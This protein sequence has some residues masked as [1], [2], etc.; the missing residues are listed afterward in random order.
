MARVSGWRSGNRWRWTAAFS[1]ALVASAVFGALYANGAGTLGAPALYKSFDARLVSGQIRIRPP[2]QAAYSV[3]NGVA[4]L[5]FGTVIDAA[6]GTVELTSAT[7]KA[8]GTQTGRFYDGAFRV[9]QAKASSALRPAHKTVVA[10]TL[11]LVGSLVCT[12]SGASAAAKP[13]RVRRRLWGRDSGGNW[14]TRGHNASATTVHTRWLVEDFCGG[15]ATSVKVVRG[16]VAV[17]CGNMRKQSTTHA[18]FITTCR[19]R[20][21]GRYA[22]GTVRG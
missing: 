22:A 1:S 7:G 2:G 4:V 12:A 3:L 11:T 17:S 10:T 8:G 9:S 18:G 16:L 19:F 13:R 5:P 14:I 15:R 21:R 20:T 6:R